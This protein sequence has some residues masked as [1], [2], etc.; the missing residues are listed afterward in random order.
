MYPYDEQAERDEFWFELFMCIAIMG[1]GPLAYFV[2]TCV[3]PFLKSL[4]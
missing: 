2:V 4:T 3:Y 1:T